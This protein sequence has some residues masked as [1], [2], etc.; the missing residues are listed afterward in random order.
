MI[1]LGLAASH[2]G[3]ACVL[4]GEELL[5]IQEERIVRKKRATLDPQNFAALQYLL[6]DELPDLVALCPLHD[7]EAAAAR[8]AANQRLGKL[9][10]LIVS[11]HRAHAAA[12]LA[13]SGFEAATVLVLDGAGSLTRDLPDDER[14]L[15]H[16][17]GRETVSIY[18]AEKGRLTPLYKEIAPKMDPKWREGMM[19]FTSLG[20]MYQ[21]VAQQIFGHWDAAGKVMALAPLGVAKRSVSEF[22]A[23][24]DGLHFFDVDVRGGERWPQRAGEYTALAAETQRALEV[25]V[26][27]M[28]KKARELGGSDR[29]CYAGGVALNS[30]ANTRIINESG[31]GECFIMPAAEDNGT[32]IGAAYL[33]LQ[34]LGGEWPA[35]G[36]VEDA[37]GRE[38]SRDEMLAAARGL[39]VSEPDIFAEG[40]RLLD[41]GSSL[42]WFQGRSEFG[43]RALGQR[44]ILLDPRIADGKDRLNRQKGRESFRPFAP[45]ILAEKAGEWFAQGGASPY[46]LQ[47]WRFREDK[48]KLVPAVVH[49][50][51]T[52]RVQTV[53]GGRFRQLIEAFEKLS[54]IPMILNTSF[55]FAG[56]PIVETPEDAIRTFQKAN[57]DALILGDFLIRRQ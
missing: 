57:L 8:L 55:N 11:H 39:D 17:E 13:Q 9:P 32:A 7:A 54:G 20:V 24:E 46:M 52:G 4:R 25:G 41:R 53:H 49:N 27:A 18:R 14:A 42:G 31:F 28:V 36:I 37:T 22:L 48:A 21:S 50:D 1:I 34:Q 33:G 5:A 19:P 29:L 47:V 15:V 26:L 6:G 2:N 38:Y 51:G 40:A 43:P 3:A 45:A 30:V 56:E 23:V 35:T 12:V 10:S 44:S 16:G